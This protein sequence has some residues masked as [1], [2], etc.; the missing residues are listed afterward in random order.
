MPP[1]NPLPPPPGRGAEDEV[2]GLTKRGRRPRRGGEAAGNGSRP[3]VWRGIVSRHRLETAANLDYKILVAWNGKDRDRPARG[4]AAPA[5]TPDI[6]W[7]ADQRRKVKSE[8]CLSCPPRRE[9]KAVAAEETWLAEIRRRL[10]A[11]QE[12][13]G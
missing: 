13:G 4:S 10:A 2:T 11:S 7:A 8:A 5:A 9:A 6:H 12:E 3:Q 1:H